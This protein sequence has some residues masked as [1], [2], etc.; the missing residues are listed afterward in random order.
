[1]VPANPDKFHVNAVIEFQDGKH[2]QMKIGKRKY[3]LVKVNLE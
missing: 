2:Y 1:M 3:A